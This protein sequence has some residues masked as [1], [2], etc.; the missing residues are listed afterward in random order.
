[1]GWPDAYEGSAKS[2]EQIA[3][4]Q[5]ATY[6]EFPGKTWSEAELQLGVDKM[7]TVNKRFLENQTSQ[8]KTFEFTDDPNAAFKNS[9]TEKEYNYLLNS[10]HQLTIQRGI[11]RAIKK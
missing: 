1:M 11:Y 6:F 10:G 4:A 9:Y 3:K 5:G 8:G 2:Y 7:W